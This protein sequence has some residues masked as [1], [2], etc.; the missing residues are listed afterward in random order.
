MTKY[1]EIQAAFDK[2]GGEREKLV[3]KAAPL[4]K[5]RDALV[6]KI[7]PLEAELRD[8]NQQI[9]KVERPRLAEI[10]NQRAALAR[11]MGARSLS[12]GDRK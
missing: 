2:L 11:A 12:D 10:D 8:L 9:A 7:Q 3:A 5:R 4:R 6:A 1:P